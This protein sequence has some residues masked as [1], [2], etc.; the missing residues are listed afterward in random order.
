MEHAVTQL[1]ER[2]TPAKAE[3]TTKTPQ[4]VVQSVPSPSANPIPA[5]QRALRGVPKSVLEKVTILDS[6]L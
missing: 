4:D 3:E 2:Q 5:L 1:V 6:G